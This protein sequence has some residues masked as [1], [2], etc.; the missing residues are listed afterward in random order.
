MA[1]KSYLDYAGLKRVLKRFIPGIRKVWHG[2][3]EEWEALPAAEKAKYDQAEITEPDY[4]KEAFTNIVAA[5]DNRP[6]TSGG[7]ASFLD[8]IGVN[9]YH[10]GFVAQ[11]HQGWKYDQQYTIPN[12]P[13]GKYLLVII[14]QSE[15]SAT[16]PQVFVAAL[17]EGAHITKSASTDIFNCTA[18]APKI[19]DITT[20]GNVTLN[21]SFYKNGGSDRCSFGARLIRLR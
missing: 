8:T 19:I 5:G 11:T 7:F 15:P 10:G 4:T 6:L 18:V 9:Q 21:Y 13:K 14:A 17:C 3:L 16:V 12:V 2:T 20:A 1:N